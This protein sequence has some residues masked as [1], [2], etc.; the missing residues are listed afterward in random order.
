MMMFFRE[1]RANG[2]LPPA[3]SFFLIL[4]FLLFSVVLL[5]KK[6]EIESR[7][8]TIFLW[9]S[10][11]TKHAVVQE[12]VYWWMIGCCVLLACY[13]L[14]A[15]GQV[16]V[17]TE[18]DSKH[19][20]MLPAI[21]AAAKTLLAGENPYKVYYLPW[22]F[23][24]H[25]LPPLWLPFV[26]A[27]FFGFDPRY[28]TLLTMAGIFS[29]ILFSFAREI[30]GGG[31]FFYGL[32]FLVLFALLSCSGWFIDFVKIQHNGF[33]L[34]WLTAFAAAF[35]QRRNFLCLLLFGVCLAARHNFMVAAPIFFLFLFTECSLRRFIASFLVVAG[36]VFT[37]VAPFLLAS[38]SDFLIE[39]VRWHAKIGQW[40]AET[41][42][43]ELMTMF[44]LSGYLLHC[45]IG[46]KTI[47]YLQWGSLLVLYGFCLGKP[48][49]RE[50]VIPI[51]ALA[52][53]IFNVFTLSPWTYA[54]MAPAIMLLFFYIYQSRTNTERRGL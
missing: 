38:V 27:S 16:I 11:K 32:G 43:A 5:W 29:I 48:V 2:L 25:F 35:Y 1:N 30:R 23:T 39:P 33:Y 21:L 24:F 50:T 31:R 51:M 8:H 28:L 44:G 13:G 17:A 41:H 20:D 19:A 37:I 9:G 22:A 45:G 6:N 18:I 34:L 14:W 12:V 47:A 49:S 40:F 52:I 10:R 3:E 42:P 4:L 46:V 54:Y 26:V 36:V 15:R 7:V 53:V